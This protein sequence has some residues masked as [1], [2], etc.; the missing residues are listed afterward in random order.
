MSNATEEADLMLA[1]N[2]VF[3]P[4]NLTLRKIPRNHSLTPDFLILKGANP[5]AFCEVK[6]PRDDWLDVLLEKANLCAIVGGARKDPTFNR[7]VRLST[8]AAKQFEAVNKNRVLPNILCFINHDDASH[9]GDLVETYTG[10]FHATNG[11]RY[12]TMQHTASL[13]DKAKT[14][15]DICIWINANAKKIEGYLFNQ[16]AS[17]DYEADLCNL[18]GQSA[19][20]ISN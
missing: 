17:P 11:G 4:R 5:V 18:L 10:I 19:S 1:E 6:S 12:M 2:L 16:N 3:K 7:I 14:Q 13:L 15:I 20:K 9:Y 8:K